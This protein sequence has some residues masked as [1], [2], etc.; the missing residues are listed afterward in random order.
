[1]I[2]LKNQKFNHTK[3]VE[4]LFY[5]FPLSFILGNLLVSIHL[6]IFIISSL[7][8]IKKERMSFKIKMA[9]WLL[10]A[11]FLYIFLSTTI[12]FQSPG[13][14]SEKTKDRG[15][16]S[17]PT[18]KSFIL[19]YPFLVSINTFLSKHRG[20]CGK[21]YRFFSFENII[22]NQWIN[23]AVGIAKSTK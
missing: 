7:F 12:K 5:T 17:D 16:G 9:H 14:L 11:F 1:M 22:S 21:V 2:N 10:I 18:F 19:L 15:I 8:L 20:F 4:I 23:T 3:L 6:I 13:F